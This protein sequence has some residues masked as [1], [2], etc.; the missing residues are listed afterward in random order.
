LV[1]EFSFEGLAEVC[2]GGVET[3]EVRE[4]KGVAEVREGEEGSGGKG[5]GRRGKER[6]GRREE[7]GLV[8]CNGRA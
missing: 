3:G 5:G 7:E 4:E 2:N 6:G 8:R 1:S